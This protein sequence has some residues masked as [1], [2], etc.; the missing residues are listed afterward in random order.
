MWK[1][2][3][4][5]WLRIIPN[6]R[7]CFT[8]PENR[9]Q[10]LMEYEQMFANKYKIVLIQVQKRRNKKWNLSKKICSGSWFSM[11]VYL[12]DRLK[13]S[14]MIGRF[15]LGTACRAPGMRSAA[16][17]L[18]QWNSGRQGEGNLMDF[19]RFE[20]A[21]NIAGLRKIRQVLRV[22]D[23]RLSSLIAWL[24]DVEFNLR[25]DEGNDDNEN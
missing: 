21:H 22:L 23:C 7:S 25:H 12:L 5:N 11:V 1:Y 20:L 6:E 14:A 13:E 3:P 4:P 15:T 8:R 2:H 19:D 10:S 9:L 17:L 24:D 18:M 16:V